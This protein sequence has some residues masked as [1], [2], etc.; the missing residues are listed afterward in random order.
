MTSQEITDFYHSLESD[1]RPVL[2]EPQ[3]LVDDDWR[4]GW[5]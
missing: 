5:E 3:A 4:F 1:H 2:P